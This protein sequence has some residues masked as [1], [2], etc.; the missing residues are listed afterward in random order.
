[1]CLWLG[2]SKGP[3]W[4]ALPVISPRQLRG[5]VL[6]WLSE[7]LDTGPHWKEF[8]TGSLRPAR[9]SGPPGELVTEGKAAP[10]GG[11]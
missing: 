11:A 5:L 10:P 3:W 4:G 9:L 8:P 7:P 2:E 6:G 1:M